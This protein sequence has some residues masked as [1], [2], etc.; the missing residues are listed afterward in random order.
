MEADTEA[1]AGHEAEVEEDATVPSDG[2]LCTRTE[3]SGTRDGG[4]VKPRQCGDTG[5]MELT[6][7]QDTE[8]SCTLPLLSTQRP[9]DV[10]SVESESL[11]VSSAIVKWPLQTGGIGREAIGGFEK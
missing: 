6:L 1:S 2:A 4:S 11:L 8:M 9:F 3:T 5:G 10:D 7:R